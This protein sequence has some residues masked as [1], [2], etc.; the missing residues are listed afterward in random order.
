MDISEKFV[1]TKQEFVKFVMEVVGGLRGG[2]LNIENQEVQIPDDVE[3]E[4]KIKY[5]EDE[6]ECK[7][8]LKVS[9]PKDE[10]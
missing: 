5:D 8:A 9:W 4:Y 2:S 10:A 3:V 6:E 7:L 1:G